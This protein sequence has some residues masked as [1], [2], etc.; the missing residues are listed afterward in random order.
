MA[1]DRYKV[2]KVECNPQGRIEVRVR[3]YAAAVGEASGETRL[4]ILAVPTLD[5]LDEAVTASTDSQDLSPLTNKIG[6]ERSI[7]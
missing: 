2:S 7:P 1:Y 3:L 5:A 4:L 6:V